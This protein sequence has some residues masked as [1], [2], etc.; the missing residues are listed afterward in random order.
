MPAELGSMF[1]GDSI[2][3]RAVTKEVTQ[4]KASATAYKSLPF[5]WAVGGGGQVTRK[6]LSPMLTRAGCLCADAAPY[7]RPVVQDFRLSAFN[8]IGHKHH[9]YNENENNEDLK[10]RL[11]PMAEPPHVRES[12]AASLSSRLIGAFLMF[13][14]FSLASCSSDDENED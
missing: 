13:A 11:W 5:R 8:Q 3:R 10:T 1:L 9:N 14:A 6:V 7:K 2:P 4:D 12:N